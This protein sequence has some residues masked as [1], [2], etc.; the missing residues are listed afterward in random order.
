[1]RAKELGEQEKGKGERVKHPDDQTRNG[2][3]KTAQRFGLPSS[4][5]FKASL[6]TN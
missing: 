4:A 5:G 3:N 1:M 2:K 6:T